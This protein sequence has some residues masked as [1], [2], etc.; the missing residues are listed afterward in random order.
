V[1]KEIVDG[2][3]EGGRDAYS[4]YVHWY[5]QSRGTVMSCGPSAGVVVASIVQRFEQG[6]K[7]VKVVTKLSA[8]QIFCVN[9][10]R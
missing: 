1:V 9:A 8:G 5:P 2:G 6:I 10:V 3:D 7:I 4:H